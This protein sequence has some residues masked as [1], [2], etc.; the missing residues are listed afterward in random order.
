[1]NVLNGQTAKKSLFWCNLSLLQS[2]INSDCSQSV[3]LF[4]RKSSIFS[5][6]IKEQNN[7]NQSSLLR[8]PNGFLSSSKLRYLVSSPVT[9]KTV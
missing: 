5:V 7:S 8:S 1:M 4:Q 3:F 2:K 6:L 9:F